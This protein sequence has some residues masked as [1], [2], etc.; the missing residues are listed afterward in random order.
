MEGSRR[1]QVRFP[2][3]GR[4][5]VAQKPFQGIL[6]AFDVAS[7]SGNALPCG[8]K[9]R[10]ALHGQGPEFGAG[11]AAHEPEQDFQVGRIAGFGFRG[12]LRQDI[13]DGAVAFG[14]FLQGFLHLGVGGAE[15]A[16]R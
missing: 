5:R 4:G 6:Q 13:Q 1:K 11:S 7:G 16:L 15:Q 14:Q 10:Q 8:Q 12:A 9:Q 2:G 3:G